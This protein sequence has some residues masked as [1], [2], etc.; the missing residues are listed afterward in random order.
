MPKTYKKADIA[1]TEVTPD[2]N[3]VLSTRR[4][5][6][7]PFTVFMLIDADPYE[8]ERDPNK[9]RYGTKSNVKV[10]AFIMRRATHLTIS[11]LSTYKFYEDLFKHEDY[12]N[13]V[14]SLGVMP[15]YMFESR[16]EAM[17]KMGQLIL[18]H[19]PLFFFK[20]MNSGGNLSSVSKILARIGV[21][22]G[23]G[24]KNTKRIL[25]KLNLLNKK[26]TKSAIKRLIATGEIGEASSVRA[27]SDVSDVEDS[28]EDS[29]EDIS[30]VD[31]SDVEDESDVDSNVEDELED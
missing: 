13:R 23:A 19:K 22:G 1:E 28:A 9:L 14:Q 29:V 10:L 31:D 24:L 18:E 7:K 5:H 26:P 4:K 12:I 25:A 11:Q 20:R 2:S 17:V 27:D 15:L 21:P 6:N 30:D 16:D 3:R 8:P